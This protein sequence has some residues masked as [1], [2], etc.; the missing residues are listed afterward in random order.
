MERRLFLF[1][2]TCLR[3][4]K[5]EPCKGSCTDVFFDA[6]IKFIEASKERPFFVYVKR[7]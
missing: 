7:L 5:P 2:D 3:N 1:D 6:A 4:G